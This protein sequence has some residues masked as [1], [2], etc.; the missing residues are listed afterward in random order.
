VH[1]SSPF[2]V[3]DWPPT[4]PPA[5]V[6]GLPI[7]ETAASAGLAH[8]VKTFEGD[9][10]GRS[11]TWFLGCLNQ[12]TGQGSYAALEAM[13]VELARRR[14]TFNVVHAASTHGS[15]R[16]DEHLVIVPDSGAGELAGIAGSGALRVDDDGTHR[17]LLD[18]T[19]PG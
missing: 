9:I 14:G 11:V 7:P 3:S 19:L 15:D 16:Y 4:E 2:T 17:L 18:Y 12:E 6:G 8:L 10:R 1:A 5:E 13:D